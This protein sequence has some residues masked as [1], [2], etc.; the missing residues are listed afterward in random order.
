MLI[1]GRDGMRLINRRSGT[2]PDGT[3]IRTTESMR[4]ARSTSRRVQHQMSAR[5]A[6]RPCGIRFRRHTCL[7][8]EI[9]I[10]TLPIKLNAKIS[11][12]GDAKGD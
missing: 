3:A 6:A 4:A 9:S 5:I 11:I 12:L 2:A 7:I 8:R 1:S 10:K